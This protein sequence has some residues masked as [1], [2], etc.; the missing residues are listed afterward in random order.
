VIPK[1]AWV[2]PHIIAIHRDEKYYKNANDFVPERWMKSEGQED[3]K[4]DELYKWMPFGVGRRSCFGRHLAG[5][6]LKIISCYLLSNFKFVAVKKTVEVEY[7]FGL[8]LKGDE[9]AFDIQEL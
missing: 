9:A 2:V 7:K 4:V 1:G 3:D 6:E 5:L 8:R